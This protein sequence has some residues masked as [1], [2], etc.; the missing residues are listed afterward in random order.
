MR[1]HTTTNQSSNSTIKYREGI[2]NHMSSLE[3][4]GR[5]LYHMTITYR[6][7]ADRIYRESD[8]NT[9]FI[10]FYV[11]KLLPLVLGTKNIHTNAKKQIQPVTYTFLD[12]HEMTPV[13]KNIIRPGSNTLQESFEFPIRLHHHS[14]LAVHPETLERF[15]ELEG[16]NTLTD[17]QLSNKIMTSDLKVCDPNRVMYASKMMYKYP[18]FLSFPDRMFRQHVH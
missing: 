10:N 7:Y 16:T 9:F 17:S 5:V 14:I 15:Q 3:S 1:T 18:D 2:A 12:E 4:D 13:K 11:K 8:V 6:P